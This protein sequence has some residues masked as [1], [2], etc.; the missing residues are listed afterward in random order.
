MNLQWDMLMFFLGFLAGAVV[1]LG[2]LLLAKVRRKSL[3]EGDRFLRK[4]G[5]I[6][7]QRFLEAAQE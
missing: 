3:R 4:L 1:I 2:G 6:G 7:A 5:S